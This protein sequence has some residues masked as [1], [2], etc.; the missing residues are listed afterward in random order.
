MKDIIN[1]MQKGLSE[2]SPGA[3]TAVESANKALMAIGVLII[4]ILF[5]LE[6][7]SWYKFIRNQG[8]DVT[9]RLFLEIGIKYFIALFLCYNSAKIFDA[10]I[11]VCN[12]MAHLVGSTSVADVF[13]W[14][15]GKKG[16]FFIKIFVNILC[17]LVGGITV[18]STN[19]I[20]LLRFIEMYLLKGIAPIIVA[21]FMNDG[22]R[23]IA[24]GFFKRCGAIALQGVVI[25]LLFVVWSGINAD[26]LITIDKGS[27]LG[28]FVAGFTYLG[29]C[30]VFL[31]M[32][33]G[34][35]RMAK[36][37]LQVN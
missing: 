10:I 32:L 19:L 29:K 11:W 7:A 21:F 23:D 14:E 26:S 6:M 37:L 16:N 9:W 25:V 15:N 4:L 36:S 27:W 34:S 30:I 17:T 31:V 12:A 8:G 35:Q 28:D 20:T 5:F 13:K 18:L 3:N 1:N 33:F 22:T 2:Y 24:I